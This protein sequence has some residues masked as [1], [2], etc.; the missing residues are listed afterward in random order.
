MKPFSIKPIEHKGMNISMILKKSALYIVGLAVLASACSNGGEK[1]QT[2]VNKAGNDD[3][4]I[5]IEMMKWSPNKFD[6]PVDNPIRKQIE[7][8]LNIE[9]KLTL[10]PGKREAFEQSFMTRIAAGDIPDLIEM[11]TAE[12]QKYAEQGIIGSMDELLA[13]TPDLKDS[14][15]QEE[16]MFAQNNGK[17]YG[18]P[19]IVRGGQPVATFLRKDWLDKLQLKMPTTTEEL[20]EVMKAFVSKDPDGNGKDDTYGYSANSLND[21]PQSVISNSFGIPQMGS[22]EPG[23]PMDWIDAKGQLHFAPVSME[24]KNYLAYMSKLYAAKV[25]DP[26]LPSNTQ[27]SFQQKMIQGQ[28][29]VVTMVNPHN[30]MLEG[31]PIVKAAKEVNPNAQWAYVPPVKGPTGLFGNNTGFS[32]SPS[33]VVASQNALKDPIKAE[34]IMKLLDYMDRRENGKTGGVTQ[35][36]GLEGI[37]HTKENGVITKMLPKF[38]EDKQAYMGGFG[39]TAILP[40]PVEDKLMYSKSDYELMQ[41]IRSGNSKGNIIAN[42]F[43]GT[44][45][46]PYDGNKYVMEMALKFIYGKESLDKWDEYVNTLNDRY[47][48]KQVQELR[49]KDLKDR[50]ILK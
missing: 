13:K 50:G 6:E 7:G 34:R 44:L 33:V 26:D 15:M 18:I 49:T 8:D 20:F 27:Q 36:Y 29:G 16:W 2:V 17:I 32:T 14:R 22:I 30:W 23:I 4:K 28:I 39:T 40:D 21:I 45:P 1:P 42:N 37:H 35:A 41:T 19:R 48:Y 46:F 3:K 12:V 24:F 9:Y 38:N 47:K 31:K 25:L 5:M 11:T 10:V 43:Y